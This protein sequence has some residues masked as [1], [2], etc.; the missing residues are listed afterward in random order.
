MKPN[1]YPRCV[2]CTLSSSNIRAYE[3]YEA[4]VY[5][6][7]TLHS[8]QSMMFPF[9]FRIS[10]ASLNQSADYVELSPLT[11]ENFKGKH[12]IYCSED[13]FHFSIDIILLAHLTC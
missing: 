13:I 12:H 9:I 7:Q 10:F 11:K 8:S 4:Y 2:I 3:V 1:L 6:K 5:T